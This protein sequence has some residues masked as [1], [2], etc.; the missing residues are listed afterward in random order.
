MNET[1]L[2]E[3]VIR[4][5]LA[6]AVALAEYWVMTGPHD[7]LVAKLWHHLSRFCYNTAFLFGCAGLQFEHRYYEAVLCP[8][9]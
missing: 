5:A 1:S 9:K 3:M 7:N 4:S 6:I 8:L 2:S